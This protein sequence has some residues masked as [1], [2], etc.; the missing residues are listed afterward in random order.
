MFDALMNGREH[1]L[2]ELGDGWEGFAVW[3]LVY[4]KMLCK[5]DEKGK[6]TRRLGRDT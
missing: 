5:G 1:M 3:R 4:R 2:A 6:L